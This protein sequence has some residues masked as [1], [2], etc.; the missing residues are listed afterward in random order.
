MGVSDVWEC[1]YILPM[2]IRLRKANKC[3]PD[4]DEIYG[5]I[6]VGI[7][8]M[9]TKLMP[10][11]DKAYLKHINEML[12]EDVQMQMVFNALRAAE[13]YVDTC[14]QPRKIV[15][16]LVKVVQSRLKNWVRD[17]TNRRLKVDIVVESSLT[18][19]AN[20][21]HLKECNLQG[22]EVWKEKNWKNQTQNNRRQQWAED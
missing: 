22:A 4:I 16:Y 11:E 12:S 19:D 13:T 5:E 14:K 8:K 15:N 6:I 2:A 21:F 20:E 9:A 3:P 7:V 10:V 17:T 18:F 1:A